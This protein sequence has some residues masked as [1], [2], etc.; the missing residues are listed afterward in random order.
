MQLNCIIYGC[1][2]E[3]LEKTGF[4]KI[5]PS[6]EI[7]ILE[8]FE[9]PQNIPENFDLFVISSQKCKS[10]EIHVVFQYVEFKDNSPAAQVFIEISGAFLCPETKTIF[11]NGVD[12]NFSL[13]EFY[14]F[15]HFVLNASRWIA[16]DWLYEQVWGTESTDKSDQVV[17][18]H[19][20]NIRKK[21]RAHEINNILI[22]NKFG[23]Y[24]AEFK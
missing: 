3:Y 16:T 11:L 8:N 1:D 9:S 5:F 21:L 14:I 17:K 10:E 18:T 12:A 19:L 15:L 24:I 4:H 23:G 13:I 20:S 7:T 22:T 6:A 2:Q